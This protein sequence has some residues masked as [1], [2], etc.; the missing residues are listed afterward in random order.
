MVLRACSRLLRTDDIVRCLLGVGS[1]A[2]AVAVAVEFSV[3]RSEMAVSELRWLRFKVDGPRGVLS[4]VG[5]AL[6]TAIA[7]FRADAL[8]GIRPGSLG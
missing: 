8:S 1:G 3:L 4:R 2:R 7:G 5:V 6:T